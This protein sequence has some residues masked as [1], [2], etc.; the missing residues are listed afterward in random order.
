MRLDN[1]LE[2]SYGPCQTFFDISGILHQTSC[3]E[4]PQQNGRVERKHRHLLEIARA[5]RFQSGLPLSFWGDCVLTAAYII[6]RLYSPILHNVSPHE[7]LFGFSPNYN[8]MKTFGCLAIAYNPS[9]TKNKF[10]HK[11]VPCIFLGYPQSQKAYTLLNL[12]TKQTFTSRDV[13]FY[14]H[15]F[16]YN[17]YSKTNYLQPIPTLLFDNSTPIVPTANIL[18][19]KGLGS[20]GN[21]PTLSSPLNH[22]NSTPATSTSP[23]H[24]VPSPVHIRRSTRLSSAPS[25]HSDYVIAFA[26][27]NSPKLHCQQPHHIATFANKIVHHHYANLLSTMDNHKELMFFH[28]A[29]CDPAWVQAMN[30]ELQALESNGTWEITNLPPR[31]KA[32]DSKWM[33]KTKY[34]SDGSIERLKARLVILGCRQKFGIDYGETFAHVAKLTTV[35]TLLAIVSIRGWMTCQMDVS[36]AFLHGDLFEDVYNEVASRVSGSK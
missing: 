8:N 14:E 17:H 12:L 27:V 20:I 22:Q 28:E 3:V 34:N 23:P 33:Y 29:V 16:P 7:K 35:R 30:L 13:K 19:A 9:L 11:G 6:N 26:T 31:R 2:F 10:N 32:I 21:D 15:S 5:I 36:N 4:R 25:W 18:D 1:A 24:N